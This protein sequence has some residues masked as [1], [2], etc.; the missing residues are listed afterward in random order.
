MA[1]LDFTKDIWSVYKYFDLGDI[2]V[3]EDDKRIYENAATV[4]HIYLQELL[5]PDDVW[6]TKDEL[7]A[8]IAQSRGT[9]EGAFEFDLKS[10]TLEAFDKAIQTMDDLLIPRGDPPVQKFPDLAIHTFFAL[11]YLGINGHI[12]GV[13]H[14]IRLAPSVQ[15]LAARLTNQDDAASP[16]TDVLIDS[17]SYMLGTINLAWI[18]HKDDISVNP[19]RM[20]TQGILMKK[21]I[22]SAF[23]LGYAAPYMVHRGTEGGDEVQE[24]LA[25]FVFMLDNRTRHFQRYDYINKLFELWN[26]FVSTYK[27]E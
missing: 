22:I 27:P 4:S 5:G 19:E 20:R 12:N 7:I 21:V 17:T 23:T 26:R 14:A 3:T 24:R 16:A 9:F 25:D 18:L 11:V 6:F 15:S 13:K 2:S 10:D 8:L 1:A